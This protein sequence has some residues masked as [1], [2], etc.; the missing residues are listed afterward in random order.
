MSELIRHS[1]VPACVS[2]TNC[3]AKHNSDYHSIA[4]RPPRGWT[5]TYY[6]IVNFTWKN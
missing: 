1:N 4:G 2:K 6:R 5:P 3:N